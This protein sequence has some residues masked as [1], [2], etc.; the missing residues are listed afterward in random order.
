[1]YK[2]TKNYRMLWGGLQEGGREALKLGSVGLAWAA[3]E[4][5]MERVPGGVAA[6]WREVGAGAGTGALFALVCK[7][8]QG[9]LIDNEDDF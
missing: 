1:M 9:L 2:K 4:D 7:C 8:L 6:E 3:G 5:A